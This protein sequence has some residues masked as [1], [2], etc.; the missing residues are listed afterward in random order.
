[1]LENYP[2]MTNFKGYNRWF[3]G[4]VGETNC[5]FIERFMF[6]RMLRHSLSLLSKNFHSKLIR[7]R[8]PG[9]FALYYIVNFDHAP[10]FLVLDN[11]RTNY[12]KGSEEVWFI[13]GKSGLGKRQST[14]QLTVVFDRIP[15][16]RPA[17]IFQGT[18]KH[19]EATER[20]KESY[21]KRVNVHF[22]KKDLV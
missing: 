11:E 5:T 20:E 7:K 9:T 3:N 2:T 15:R 18:G 10:M 21:N 19:N 12:A 1:M 17:I 6:R 13:S 16:V 8:K 4:I 14:V 22:Q